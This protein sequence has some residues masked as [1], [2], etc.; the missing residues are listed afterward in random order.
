MPEVFPA[1][2]IEWLG[3]KD[4]RIMANGYRRY[5]LPQDQFG[6]RRVIVEAEGDVIDF[7]KARPQAFSIAT[8]LEDQVAADERYQEFC[9]NID[10]YVETLRP[11]IREIVAQ[12]LDEQTAAQKLGI[13][14]AK[15]P[16]K[17]AATE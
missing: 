15:K 3:D 8:D 14:K 2:I 12:S 10:L 11:V 5:F 9:K 4:K 16:A 1:R 17:K 7:C 6:G 13:K